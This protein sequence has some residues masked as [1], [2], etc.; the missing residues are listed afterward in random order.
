MARMSDLLTIEKARREA[1]LLFDQDPDL[2]APEHQA[3]AE[4][5][6]KFWTAGAADAS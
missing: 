4:R 3:L 1:R 6:A 2:Q 5:L